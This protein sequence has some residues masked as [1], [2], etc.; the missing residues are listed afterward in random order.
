MDVVGGKIKKVDKNTPS[1]KSLLYAPY[2]YL[3]LVVCIAIIL[4]IVFY[5]GIYWSFDDSIYVT[6]ALQVAKGIFNP[7]SSPYAFGWAFPYFVWL[8]GSIFGFTNS[9]LVTLTAIEYISLII[10]TY[11]LGTKLFRDKYTPVLGAFIVCISPFVLQYSTRLLSDM[12]LGVVATLAIIFL[13]SDRKIDWVLAGILASFLA[14]IKL[15][16][17]AFILFFGIYVLFCKEKRKYV[18]PAIIVGLLVYIVP[19]LVITHNP[20]YAIEN[21]G[22]FQTTISPA[23]VNSNYLALIVMLGSATVN[24]SAG[25]LYYQIYPLGLMLWFALLATY[26]IISR[27][28]KELYLLVFIFWGFL[29]Y[30]LFGSIT[31]SHYAVDAIVPRYLITVAAPFALL[32]SYLIM[33]VYWN[34]KS[35]WG[36]NIAIFLFAM[37]LLLLILSLWNTYIIIYQYKIIIDHQ[38]SPLLI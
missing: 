15:L 35:R 33:G 19:F 36:R 14:Y 8:S 37:L 1:K 32:I 27:R 3:L 22:T 17:L 26:F 13:L 18:I 20:L 21:Y 5:T 24:K 23:S 10:L 2:V 31:L 30:I 7:I 6:F 16:G 11:I 38:I 12:L 28:R 34:V 25:S 29:S 4:G 9:G